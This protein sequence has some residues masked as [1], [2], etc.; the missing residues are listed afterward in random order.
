MDNALAKKLHEG[1][2]DLRLSELPNGLEGRL[3]AYLALLVKW[4]SAYN[5]TAVRNPEQMLI[6]HLLDSLSILPLLSG[7]TLIDVGTGPGLPGLVLALANPAFEVSLLDSNGKKVRFVRQVIAELKVANATAV[8]ARAESHVGRF[9]IVTSRAFAT[10]ADMVEWSGHLVSEGGAL[11]A[12]KGVR[13]DQEVA[14]LP[15]G[16]RVDG[17]FAL[18]VPFLDE[19]RHAVRIVKA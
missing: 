13:P 14:A 16:Y 4:N 5:L 19:E 9:D 8:Q 18:R 12:M 2:S 1:I 6:R 10:L 17:I 11:L 7:K 15:S 3:L